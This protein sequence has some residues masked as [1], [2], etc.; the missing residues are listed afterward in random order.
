MFRSRADPAAGLTSLINIIDPIEQVDCRIMRNERI[1]FRVTL[2]A[3]TMMCCV[4]CADYR[5]RDNF[6][7]AAKQATEQNKPLFIYYR[8]WLNADST[9]MFN[10]VLSQPDVVAEFQNSINCQLELDWPENREHMAKYGVKTVP[11]YVIV[12]PDGRFVARAGLMSKER[13][14]RFARSALAMGGKPV[15][16]PPPKGKPALSRSVP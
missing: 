1:H 5:W 9:R 12:F 10:D 8:H 7:D 13:F 11:G 3:C 14:L 2:L 6:E 15:A 4:G 16:P